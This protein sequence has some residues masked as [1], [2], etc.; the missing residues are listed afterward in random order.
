MS[1]ADSGFE[2]AETERYQKKQELILDAAA[3][4]MNDQGV[5]G[6]TFAGVA[7]SVDLNPTSVTYYFKRKELL[8]AAAFRR[9]LDRLDQMVEKAAQAPTPRAKVLAYIG[10]HFE[11]RARL[12]QGK[13]RPI[14]VLSDLRTLDGDVRAELAERYTRM[15]RKL[16]SFFGSDEN[17]IRRTLNVARAHVLIE[18]MFW[19]PVWLPRYSIFDYPRVKDRLFDLLE[20][21][22]AA[23][24]AVWEPS[25]ISID[26]RYG[27]PGQEAGLETYLRAA[28]RLV[29]ERGYRGASVEL[30]A[31]ELNVTKGSFYHHL[32][33][34]DDLVLNCFRR[35]YDR[36]SL[37]QRTAAKMDND[38]WHKLS[39]V[40]SVLL[41]AQLSGNFPMLRTTAIQALPI[42]FR[43]GVVERSDRMALRFAGMVSDGIADGSIRAVDPMIAGHTVM[44]ML[45]SAYELRKWAGGFEVDQAI[46]YYA[47]T[48]A[49]GMFNDPPGLGTA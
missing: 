34:K 9:T 27:D 43:G 10:E 11:F 47:S 49:F 14:A 4:L 29:N 23:S 41:N 8:A 15:V 20:N 30:I 31:S 42:E 24:S 3:R 36:V 17:P 40:M 7:Q 12:L 26:G 46:F 13:D 22:L 35:S 16:R 1:S 32:D 18:N 21:G 33:A 2:F 44:N 25:D 6:L 28:T 39:S 38:H 5:K 48:V 37:S 45:D 19:L